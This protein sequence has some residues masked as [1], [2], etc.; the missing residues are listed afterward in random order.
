MRKSG[1]S[2]SGKSPLQMRIGIDATPI[3]LRK[4]GIGYYTQNLLESLT[5]LDPENEYLLFKTTG[6]PPESPLSFLD[7]PNICVIQTSKE[8][9][10]WRSR[11]EHIDLYHGTN[12]RLRGKGRMG[13]VVTIHD[14]A[15]KRYPQFLKKKYGQFLSI[16]K[17]KRDVHRADRVI[18]VSRQTARDIVEFLKVD[19]R[20]IKV[21]YHGVDSQFRPDVPLGFI[22]AVRN[23]YGLGTSPYILWVGT[24]E[25]RKNLQALIKSYG[26][27]KTFHRE[28]SLVLGGGW[29][30]K[31][32]EIF[33]LIR[34]LGETVKVTGYLSREDLIALYAGAYLFVYPS[35]Y[36]GFGM[37]LLEAMS[38]GV[39]VIA[40][41]TSCIPEV[42]G[43]AG[44]LVNPLDV[45]Q[46]AGAITRVLSDKALHASLRE[47]GME[48]AKSFTWDRA[49]Q[50]TLVLYREIIRG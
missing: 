1:S 9:Q 44:I 15:F 46:M 29:G 6:N 37:P 38:S 36:E 23:K 14:L 12:F 18:A 32:E 3:F 43:E 21:I 45:L 39:P 22:S 5:R 34:S 11:R 19:P 8:F 16:L 20:K 26:Q 50:E 47:K 48:R 28:Y 49:A 7:R 17:T 13:N 33:P 2:T 25:P 41:N 10:K 42:V 31:Y 35:L 40:S 4:G 24:I 30:W 27:L